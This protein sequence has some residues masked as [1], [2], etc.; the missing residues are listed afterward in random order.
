MKK[1]MI[2]DSGYVVIRSQWAGGTEYLL[3]ENPNATEDERFL[4]CN[5]K[6]NS[7][8]SQYSDGVAGNNMNEAAREFETRVN[9][10]LEKVAAEL[11]GRGLPAE[12]FTAEQCIP[13][14]YGQD[15]NGK[16]V[17]I[18]ADMLA[19]EYRR[20]SEQLVYVVG[21][22]GSNAD[23][24]GSAVYCWQLS[25]EKQ[26]R[27]E[28]YQVLGIVKELPDWV[29][30]RLEAVKVQIAAEHAKSKNDRVDTR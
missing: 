5:H 13:H 4:V 23:S 15:I 25:D 12:L 27:H 18:R 21:G 11:D 8:L 19:S 16:V 20:G 17:A 7:I 24:R 1:R 9:T 10:A 3:A 28:R 29:K 26:V 2:G 30:E 14:D 6:E 22:F